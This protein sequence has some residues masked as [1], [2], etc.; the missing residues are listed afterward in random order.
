MSVES[1][2]FL[3]LVLSAILIVGV[4]Y[5]LGSYLLKRIEDRR[6]QERVDHWRR[7]QDR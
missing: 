5:E 7:K 4:V 3:V 2:Q 1:L 6:E